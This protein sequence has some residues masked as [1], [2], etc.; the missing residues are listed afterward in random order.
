MNRMWEQS[1]ETGEVSKFTSHPF[2][3]MKMLHLNV[4]MNRKANGIQKTRDPVQENERNK[5]PE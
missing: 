2:S 1:E 3:L 5:L 4:G